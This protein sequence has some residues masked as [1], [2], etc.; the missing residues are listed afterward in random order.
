MLTKSMLSYSLE[1][2]LNDLE[3]LSH[4]AV[5]LLERSASNIGG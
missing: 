2:G 4:S 3:T 5:Y 1:L